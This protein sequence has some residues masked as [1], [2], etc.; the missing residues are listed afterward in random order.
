MP[1]EM[2]KENIDSKLKLLMAGI[3][4]GCVLR[5]EGCE[6]QNMK[7]ELEEKRMESSK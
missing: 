6:I 3:K 2:I 4:E 5:E 1:L 7:K